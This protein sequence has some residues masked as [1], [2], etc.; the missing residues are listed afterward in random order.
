MAAILVRGPQIATWRN[1]DGEILPGGRITPEARTPGL[2]DTVVSPD[3][4]QV[5]SRHRN[6]S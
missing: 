2:Q 5:R 3:V 4:A 1:R 6:S